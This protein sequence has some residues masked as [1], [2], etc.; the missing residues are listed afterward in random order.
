MVMIK[1]GKPV[2]PGPNDKGNKDFARPS[3]DVK[4]KVE[5][6]MKTPITKINNDPYVLK[7]TNRGS[8]MDAS[9]VMNSAGM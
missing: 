3:M 9:N 6:E 8:D 4:T 1:N 2:V 7:V 5:K